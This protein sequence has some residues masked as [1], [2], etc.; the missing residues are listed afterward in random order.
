M[1]ATHTTVF[2]VAPCGCRLPVPNEAYTTL[3]KLDQCPHGTVWI[4]AIVNG[5]CRF[6]RWEATA[7]A[8]AWHEAYRVNVPMVASF[9]VLG[10]DADWDDLGP[11]VQLMLLFTAEAL[12]AAGLISTP[13]EVRIAEP[14]P[15]QMTMGLAEELDRQALADGQTDLVVGPT[16]HVPCRSCGALVFWRNHVGTGRPAP[17]DIEAN[18]TG[19][20]VLVAPDGYTIMPVTEATELDRFTSHFATCPNAADHRRRS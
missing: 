15:D 18:P 12:F 20:V 2:G 19:N 8:R 10:T 7:V 17:I 3:V 4:V 13:D 11:A 5:A 1:T 6:V 14:D 16:P 9:L